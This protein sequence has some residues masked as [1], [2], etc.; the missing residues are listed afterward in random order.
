MRMN[1]LIILLKSYLKLDNKK[2]ISR[3]NLLSLFSILE[4]QFLFQVDGGMR[5]SI[6]M[7]QLRSLK[8]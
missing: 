8:T 5:S 3:F 4:R 6:L 1:Q 7:I 2:I